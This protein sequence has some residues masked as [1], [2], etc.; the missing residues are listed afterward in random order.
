MDRRLAWP[1]YILRGDGPHNNH[2][3]PIFIHYCQ[4][5]ELFDAY[6]ISTHFLCRYQK[7][8]FIPHMLEKNTIAPQ[9]RWIKNDRLEGNDHEIQLQTL[10]V[11]LLLFPTN[12]HIHQR[13]R[14]EP[15]SAFLALFRVESLV[16]SF[17]YARWPDTCEGTHPLHHA[18]PFIG[19]FYPRR[20]PWL[21]RITDADELRLTSLYVLFA[22]AHMAFYPSMHHHPLF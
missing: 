6:I 15:K 1:L 10:S 12:T 22:F 21:G 20:Q 11:W 8:R 16:T 9:H 7:Q 3:L 19:C 17:T 13:H 2:S 5:P 14:G 4:T 18:P